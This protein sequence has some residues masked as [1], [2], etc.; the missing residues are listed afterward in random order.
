MEDDEIRS[1]NF[2]LIRYGG[3]HGED[4]E[5]VAILDI[6]GDNYTFEPYAPEYDFTITEHLP[7][8]KAFQ[9]AMRFVRW[10]HAFLRAEVTKI[11]DRQGIALGYEFRPLYMPS[12]FGLIDVL[13]TSYELRG[14]KIF[15]YV[16]LKRNI[17]NVFERD[18]GIDD[19]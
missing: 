4:I 1:G 18:R 7:R 5:T 3:T 15:V 19:H 11:T 12:R 16:N 6:E 17:N 10:H 8:D 13:H 9:E 2:S 14:E